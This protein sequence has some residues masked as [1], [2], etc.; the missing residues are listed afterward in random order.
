MFSVHCSLFTINVN[1][2]HVVDGVVDGLHDLLLPAEVHPGVLPGPV[3]DVVDVDGPV[4]ELRPDP[5]DEHRVAGLTG[6]V[7]D[8]GLPRLQ[9]VR[10]YRDFPGRLPLLFTR[11]SSDPDLVFFVGLCE[12]KR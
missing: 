3:E 5:L 7:H 2:D 6:Q 4:E 11:V 8:D 10:H 1:T 12:G 9:D